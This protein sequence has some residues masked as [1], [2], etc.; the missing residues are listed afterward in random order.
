MAKTLI[1]IID[2]GTNTF[3][4]LIGEQKKGGKIIHTEKRLVKLAEGSDNLDYIRNEPYQRA[5]SAIRDYKQTIDEKGITKVFAYATSG[6]RSAGN[7]DQFVL[8]CWMNYKIQIDIIDGIQE[9][10]LISKGV[11]G[12]FPDTISSALVIDIGGGSTEFCIIK[13]GT[14]VWRK[15]YELGASRLKE[16]IQPNDP[17]TVADVITFD[18]LFETELQE[19]IKQCSDHSVKVMIGSSGSFDTL[20]DIIEL[21][22]GNRQNESYFHFVLEDFKRMHRTM[23]KNDISYRLKIPGMIPLRA[24]LMPIATLLTSFVL[25]QCSISQLSMSRYS[26]KEGALFNHQNLA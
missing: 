22:S 20:V 9:A 18:S 11:I 17:L 26:L 7:S 13:N 8:D 12:A 15:S 14:N 10:D 23:L 1:A 2:L 6:L 21:E 5:L 25:N 3:N 19:V 24:E 16:N 4:L